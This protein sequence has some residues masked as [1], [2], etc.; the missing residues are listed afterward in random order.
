MV[1]PI[2]RDIEMEALTISDLKRLC[3]E[4]GLTPGKLRKQQII[5][6]LVNSGL[7]ELPTEIVVRDTPRKSILTPSRS[8]RSAI[9]EAEGGQPETRRSI[10]R[11]TRANA[12]EINKENTSGETNVTPMRKGKR[13]TRRQNAGSTESTNN[14]DEV[15]K[16]S[17]ASD[18]GSASEEAKL[19][20]EGKLRG[21]PVNLSNSVEFSSEEKHDPFELP[22]TN[23]MQGSRSSSGKRHSTRLS[24][25]KNIDDDGTGFEQETPPI[26]KIAE[27]ST[28]V[29]EIKVIQAD[30]SAQVGTAD[31]A[32]EL[33]KWQSTNSTINETPKEDEQPPKHAIDEGEDDKVDNR[34]LHSEVLQSNKTDTPSSEKG[35]KQLKETKVNDKY[36]QGAE[37]VANEPANPHSTP[38][39]VT[40]AEDTWPRKQRRT[41]N[42]NT[43]AEFNFAYDEQPSPVSSR[44]GSLSDEQATITALN[45]QPTPLIIRENTFIVGAPSQIKNSKESKNS[46]PTYF[47]ASKTPNFKKLHEREQARMESIVDHAS[48]KRERMRQLLQTTR[49]I[50]D[51]GGTSRRE[52][53]TPLKTPLKTLL[54]TPVTDIKRQYM[55]PSSSAKKILS[56]KVRSN[57]RFEL[58]MKAR[59]INIEEDANSDEEQK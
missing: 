41:W 32:S 59:G 42:L 8:R 39:S 29:D 21:T 43:T 54:K 46:S 45:Q 14:K 3:A 9:A 26:K 18:S 1:H 24:F 12:A 2:Q 28:N 30:E 38:N 20:L 23:S 11:K 57:R 7:K 33:S 40:G 49:E 19:Q 56:D 15:E 51:R 17:P 52:S 25:A 31:S 47:K 48:R 6:L 4:R 58:L 35:Q 53:K 16:Q 44:R 50:R 13:S 37:R 34:R 55:T 22:E 36:F 5:E 10:R 27:E